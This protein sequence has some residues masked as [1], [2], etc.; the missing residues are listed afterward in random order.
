MS[1]TE[2]ELCN[3]LKMDIFTVKKLLDHT[4]VKVTDKHYV[5]FRVDNVRKEL[6]EILINNF[7]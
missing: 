3:K 4:D 1:V 7:I 5:H 2:I 6:D